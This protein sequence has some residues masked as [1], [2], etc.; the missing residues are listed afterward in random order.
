MF[1]TRPVSVSLLGNRIA[2]LE[3]DPIVIVLLL[4]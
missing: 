2:T 3:R 4:V 1:E